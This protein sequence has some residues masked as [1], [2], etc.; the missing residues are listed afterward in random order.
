MPVPIPPGGPFWPPRSTI[1]HLLDWVWHW[2]RSTVLMSDHG[3]RMTSDEC[4]QSSG[5][6]QRIIFVFLTLLG[7]CRQK[8]PR[9]FSTPR[10]VSN[11]LTP[12][13]E[14]HGFSGTVL[15]FPARQPTT[16]GQRR[17]LS[18]RRASL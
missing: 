5:I 4:P 6:R 2:T 9:R 1:F 14:Q 10:G 16:G 11:R 18:M 15:N 17:K 7:R 12:Y 3:L 13:S 8:A